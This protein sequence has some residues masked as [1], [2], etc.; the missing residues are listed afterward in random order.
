[1]HSL[2]NILYNQVLFELESLVF[3]LVLLPLLALHTGSLLLAVS[4]R[5]SITF[6]FLFSVSDSWLAVSSGNLYRS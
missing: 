1:M 5:A 3:G 6:A 4:L 2:I